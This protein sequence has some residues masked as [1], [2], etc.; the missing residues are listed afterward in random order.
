[1]IRLDGHEVEEC[2]TEYGVEPVPGAVIECADE[3]EA[4]DLQDYL[5]GE[6]LVSRKVYITKWSSDAVPSEGESAPA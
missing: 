2:W 6:A 1:L 4:L 3:Q 5:G